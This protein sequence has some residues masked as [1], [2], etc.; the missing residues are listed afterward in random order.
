VLCRRG[1][2]CVAGVPPRSETATAVGLARLDRSRYDGRSANL[3]A[4]SKRAT[5]KIR[6]AAG[7]HLPAGYF[8]ADDLAAW[9]FHQLSGERGRGWQQ[10]CLRRR[11]RALHHHGS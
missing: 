4:Q 11:K 10:Y 7:V 2:S 1:R 8:S 3:E 6:Y 5:G 9:R